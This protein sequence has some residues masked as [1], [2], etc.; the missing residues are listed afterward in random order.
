MASRRFDR[1]RP[2]VDR[3]PRINHQ[4][5][6]RQVRCIDDE[7]KQLGVI[8]TADAI[9][10]AN[11]KGLDLV[12]IATDRASILGIAESAPELRRGV[13]SMAHCFGDAP[14]HD[15]EVRRI[16]SNTGRLVDNER[17]FDPHTGIPRMSA[18]PIAGSSGPGL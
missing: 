11:H 15:G 14:G 3:G 16:G 17:D 9:A 1:G 8:D 5:R 10:L 7:G 4:I 6:I 12:E 18:I 2:P 13:V